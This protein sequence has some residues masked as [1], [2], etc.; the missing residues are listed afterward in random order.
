MAG[1]RAWQQ[2]GRQVRKGE[3][4]LKI[5]GYSIK[6]ITKTD[7]YGQQPQDVQPRS[8]IRFVVARYS[9][10]A[11]EPLTVTWRRPGEDTPRTWKH[12]IPSS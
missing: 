11:G 2:L 3:N 12:P 8:A 7:P 10:A 5:L 4:A 6:K 1:Y 9:G